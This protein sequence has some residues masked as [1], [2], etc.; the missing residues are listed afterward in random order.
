MGSQSK[1]TDGEDK[2]SVTTFEVNDAGTLRIADFEKAESRADFYEGVDSQWD[3]SPAKLADAMD[4]CQPLAWKVQ[5]LYSEYRDK[6]QYEIKIAPDENKYNNEQLDRLHAELIALPEEPEEGARPWLQKASEDYFRSNIVG[7]IQPW[8][9]EPPNW[10]WEDDYLP[11]HAT[12]QGAALEYFRSMDCE[13]REPLG[14]EVIE[15]EHP[16]STYYAAELR[17]G[18]EEANA[19][20][21]AA[22]MLVRFIGCSI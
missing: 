14:V 16:G 11:E 12:S 7:K 3:R 10:V 22:G 13:S 1:P 6:I 20:A 19:V 17:T 4:E 9:S 18:I 15:G 5:S 21:E 2:G 8:F